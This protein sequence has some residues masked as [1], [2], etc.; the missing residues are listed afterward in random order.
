MILTSTKYHGNLLRDSPLSLLSIVKF[1]SSFEPKKVLKVPNETFLRITRYH[2][3]KAYCVSNDSQLHIHAIFF[4][5]EGAFSRNHHPHLSDG[6]SLP[7]LMSFLIR[8]SVCLRM[9]TFR[10]RV[11]FLRPSSEFGFFCFILNKRGFCPFAEE[12]HSVLFH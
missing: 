9:K 10:L 12:C 5:Y 6:K 11:H 7:S 8:L 2:R 3:E 4:M 1:F